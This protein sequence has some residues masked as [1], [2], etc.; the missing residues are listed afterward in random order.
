MFIKDLK[1]ENWVN[2]FICFFARIF[3]LFNSFSDKLLNWSNLFKRS[4]KLLFWNKKPFSPFDKISVGPLEQLLDIINVLLK[5]ASIITKPGSSHNDVE[6]KQSEFIKYLY[7]LSKNNFALIGDD[8]KNIYLIKV[9]NISENNISKH[10][11]NFLLYQNQTNIK[12]RDR[13]FVSYDFFLNNKYKV[14]INQKTL[15]R[16]KNYFR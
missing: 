4:N 11:D 3:F 15:Q 16:V 6:M 5:A 14:K 8:D 13:M 1:C 7:T 9:I 2:F 12:I 10:S